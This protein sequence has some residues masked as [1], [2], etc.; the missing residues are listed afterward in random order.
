[1]ATDES[2]S[3]APRFPFRA[4]WGD[5]KAFLYGV[6][7]EIIDLLARPLFWAIHRRPR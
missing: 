5:T 1:M 3:A 2:A 7:V 6:L 4:I